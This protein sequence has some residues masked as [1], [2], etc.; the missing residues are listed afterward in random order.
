MPIEEFLRKANLAPRCTNHKTFAVKLSY[1]DGGIPLCSKCY[2]E[3]LAS[4]NPMYYEEQRKRRKGERSAFLPQSIVTMYESALVDDDL[5]SLREDIATYE[6]RI[7]QL[8]SQIRDDPRNSNSWATVLDKNLRQM[9]S[10]IKSGSMTY[11]QAFK[12]IS[13][14][15]AGA[16][17]ER[18]IWAEIYSVSDLKRK[19]VATEAKRYNDLGWTPEHVMAMMTEIADVLKTLMTTEAMASF[20]SHLAKSRLFNGHQF[21]L[22]D[23][24]NL[25]TRSIEEQLFAQ[26]VVETQKKGGKYIAEVPSSE[27]LEENKGDENESRTD[28]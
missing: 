5:I 28:S 19:A 4:K 14:F 8:V 27:S 17:T 23:Q 3:Y 25:V 6:A 9:K 12:D 11:A 22:L 7:R 16:V 24:A 13:E 1:Q 21:T 10:A 18:L 15:M 2:K 20:M 26:E